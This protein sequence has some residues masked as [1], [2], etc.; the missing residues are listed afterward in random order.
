MTIVYTL[1][2]AQNT[3]LPADHSSNGCD[4]LRLK[5]TLRVINLWAPAA[6]ARQILSAVTKKLNSTEHFV[7]LTTDYLRHSVN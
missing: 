3:D 7:N 4:G 2:G 6:M 1:K 5:G